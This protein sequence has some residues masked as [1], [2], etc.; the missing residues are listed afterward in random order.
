MATLT[1]I[2]HQLLTVLRTVDELN[3]VG[4]NEPA[5]W[6]AD[7]MPIAFLRWLGPDP[8]LEAETGHGQDV[9]HQWL[10]EIDV[11]VPPA[12]LDEGGQL[13]LAQ[14]QLKCVVQNVTT[15]FRADRTLGGTVDAT[16]LTLERDADF[17]A[18]E[19]ASALYYGLTFRVTADLTEYDT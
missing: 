5:T 6:T 13:E 4:V 17:F 2:E 1:Q 9:T 3:R 10:L 7:E 19:P 8:L 11:A 16:R 15:A 18:R 12:T 14:E